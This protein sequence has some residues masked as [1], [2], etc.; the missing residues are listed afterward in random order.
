NGGPAATGTAITLGTTCRGFLVVGNK[1]GHGQAQ[2]GFN[3]YLDN[4]TVAPLNT[5]IENYN[6]NALIYPA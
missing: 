5:W 1:A 3:P 2:T 4:A 6:G